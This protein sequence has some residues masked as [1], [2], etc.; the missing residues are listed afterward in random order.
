MARSSTGFDGALC[1]RVMMLQYSVAMCAVWSRTTSASGVGKSNMAPCTLTT[2]LPNGG[3]LCPSLTRLCVQCGCQ[4]EGRGCVCPV[5]GF[6]GG[7]AAAFVGCAWTVV[8]G[9]VI[10]MS[11][12]THG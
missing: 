8:P 11:T 4:I 1:L 6:V 7:V 5:V 3:V 12:P 2:T 9:C 10:A